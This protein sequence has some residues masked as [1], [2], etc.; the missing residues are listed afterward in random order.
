M[1]NPS[2]LERGIIIK[3]VSFG[4]SSLPNTETT[5]AVLISTTDP[6]AKA[7]VDEPILVS[8]TS[9]AI[10]LFGAQESRAKTTLEVLQRYGAGSIIAV[11]YPDNPTPAQVL[12]ALEKLSEVYGKFG[13]S[14]DVIII[15]GFTDPTIVKR[16]L[17][18]AETIKAIVIF[19]FGGEEKID[20]ILAERVTDGG[21]GTKHARLLVCYGEVFKEGVFKVDNT[22]AYEDLSSHLAGQIAKLDSEKYYG[23]LP[24]N[25][26]LLGVDSTRI[27]LKLSYIENEAD[28]E[29]FNDS[30][31]V[32]V[33]RRS[34]GLVTWG[35]RNSLYPSVTNVES[36]IN[37]IRIQ[38][39]LIRI[40]EERSQ[41]FLDFESSLATARLLESSLNDALQ[42]EQMK[43]S[44]TSV[45]GKSLAEFLTNESDIPGSK[46]VYQISAALRAP[47]RLIE[48]NISVSRVTKK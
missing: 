33:N 29:K 37:A 13:V 27:P 15:P 7:V 38:D 21:M 20:D 42:K 12:S 26:L 23:K 19:D 36:W 43:G 31:I 9:Q 34:D 25:E 17:V 5:I 10:T 39:K 40:V 3:T 4:A 16:S 11:R 22:P 32:T 45:E 30:G 2:K 48:F 46:L 44:F 1:S 8:N 24:S 35:D 14:P 41:R 6:E 28:S 18:I 47:V